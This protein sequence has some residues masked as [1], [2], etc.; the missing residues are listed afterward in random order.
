MLRNLNRCC[1]QIIF[2]LHRILF[3]LI[4]ETECG[5]EMVRRDALLLSNRRDALHSSNGRVLTLLYQGK[6]LAARLRSVQVLA[7]RARS[8]AVGGEVHL[9]LHRVVLQFLLGAQC[10]VVAQVILRD[11][12]FVE[13]ADV[14]FVENVRLRQRDLD[15]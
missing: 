8:Q 1:G 5:R 13:E 2:W 7:V 9:F 6:L 11:F 10:L 14:D 15:F 3:E 12:I 4:L